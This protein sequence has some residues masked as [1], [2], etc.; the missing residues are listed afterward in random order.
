[1]GARR[2]ER[3]PADRP[4]SL[5]PGGPASRRSRFLVN[6]AAAKRSAR[7]AGSNATTAYYTSL[8][9]RSPA[10]ALPFTLFPLSLLF[11]LRLLCLVVLASYVFEFF[12]GDTV[13]PPPN[14]PR[15]RG[16]CVL[17]PRDSLYFCLTFAA[18]CAPIY[19]RLCCVTS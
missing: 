18:F 2:R 6:S 3:P 4:L 19:P 1:M 17:S 11:F 15:R 9:S 12:T 7:S 16:A 14:R 10:S 13:C 5:A 8:L